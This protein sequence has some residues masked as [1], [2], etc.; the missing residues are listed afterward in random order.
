MDLPDYFFE[1]QDDSNDEH[2]YESPRLV[3]H[4]DDETIAALTYY[5]EEVL[6]PDYKILDLMSSWISHLP[7]NT[8][9]HHVTGLGMNRAELDKNAR[10][11]ERLVHNLNH[12]PELSFK[13]DTFDAVLIAVSVQYLISPLTV[14]DE[15]VRIL[16]P[17][18]MCVVAMSHRLF[19][20]KAIYAFQALSA[21]DRISL[22]THYMQQT[23]LMDDVEFIDRSPVSGDPLWIVQ[24][25][26]DVNKPQISVKNART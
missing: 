11:D 3:T 8:N 22:V 16:K 6:R 17:G 13:N 19:P 4:I 7:K 21:S 10:L 2:F 25:K 1:R 14:F 20:T 26:K 9:Y 15:I 18:G 5:Y 12:Q 23:G 24:G